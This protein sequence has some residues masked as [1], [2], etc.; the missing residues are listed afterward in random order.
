M[1][2]GSFLLV[3][4]LGRLLGTSLLTIGAT[5][6]REAHYGALFTLTGISIAIILLTLIYR[7]SI[8]RRFRKIRAAAHLKWRAERT[9]I[10]KDKQ[11]VLKRF[12]I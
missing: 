8:E 10:K 3:V 6:F 12:Q 9:R 1:G 5:F 7:E 11:V 2:H 4:I